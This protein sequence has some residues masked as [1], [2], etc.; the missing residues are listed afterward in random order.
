ML[1]QSWRMQWRHGRRRPETPTFPVVVEPTWQRVQPSQWLDAESIRRDAEAWE[2][3]S[4]GDRHCLLELANV[5][6]VDS[7]GVALLVS[8][9][10]KMRARGRHL[11]LLAPGV[12]V[13]RALALMRLEDFFEIAADAI[14]AREVIEARK[15]ER[16]TRVVNGA[17]RSLVWQG[18]ITAANAE[19]VWQQ[20]RAEINSMSSWRKEW[21]IDLSQVRFIDSSGLGVMIHAKKYAPRR[22]ARVRF[23][24]ASPTVRNVLR[25]SK[26][27]S[28]LLDGGR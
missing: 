3:V 9:Q 1:E 23:A 18:E 16:S 14:G 11:I 10:K 28:F 7:T 15:Q 6:F 2:E 27:E 12:A 20:T 24:G 19:E 26:L 4:A 21:P 5:N 13:R 17:G 25:L 22:G 8:L